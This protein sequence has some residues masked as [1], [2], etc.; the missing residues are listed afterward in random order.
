MLD[1]LTG[2]GIF[3]YPLALCSFV[4]VFIIVERLL[5]LRPVRVMPRDVMQALLDGQEPAGDGLERSAAGRIAS[6]FYKQ[7]PDDEALKAYARLEVAR[8]ERGIF[9]L[10]I[11]IAA[12]PL[13]GLLGTVT[14]LIQV[15]AH[16]TPDAGLPDPSIFTQGIALALTTTMLGLAIAIPSI[17]GNNYLQRRID[18]LAAQLDVEV[19]RLNSSRE[20]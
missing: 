3:V 7:R 13:I 14:G 11:V 4:A 20:G 6:F 5:A 17:V 12:A 8:F 19:E 10:E 15:F 9:L 2:A 16:Y 18:L 1:I